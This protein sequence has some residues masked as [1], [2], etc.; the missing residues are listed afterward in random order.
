MLT[1]SNESNV[2]PPFHFKTHVSFQSFRTFQKAI[3]NLALEVELILGSGLTE[4]AKTY[5]S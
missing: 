4:K 3:L 1:K 5:F 2:F